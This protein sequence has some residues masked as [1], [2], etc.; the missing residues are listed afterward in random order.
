MRILV[1]GGRD[2]QDRDLIYGVLGAITARVF[3]TEEITII[4]GG[5]RGADHIA[6]GYGT[7]VNGYRHETYDADWDTFG[8]SAGHIRNQ[9]MLDSKPDIVVAFKTDFDWTFSKGGTEGMIKIAKAAGVPCIV[10]CEA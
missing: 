2:Y 9:Q 5:A 10:V 4:E 8:K 1:C 6:H 7:S 3:S